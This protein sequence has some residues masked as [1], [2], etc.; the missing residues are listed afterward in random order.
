MLGDV[1]VYSIHLIHL[2]ASPI[3]TLGHRGV[4]SSALISAARSGGR[5]HVPTVGA[6]KGAMGSQL[7]A[8][9]AAA[10]AAA[11]TASVAGER[12]GRGKKGKGKGNK[13]KRKKRNR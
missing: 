10:A 5:R 7:L 11:A 12:P 1:H 6:V 13:G 8:E 2:F 3:P 9:A 4:V